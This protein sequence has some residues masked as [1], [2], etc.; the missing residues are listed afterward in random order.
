MTTTAEEA[1]GADQSGFLECVSV[2]GSGLC[3]S[4]CNHGPDIRLKQSKKLKEDCK[5]LRS[6]CRCLAAEHA[7]W[8]QPVPACPAGR[9]LRAPA[10]A[11]HAAP[12]GAPPPA[13][14]PEMRGQAPG[15]LTYQALHPT[16]ARC[17]FLPGLVG[18]AGTHSGVCCRCG[19]VVVGQRKLA[20]TLGP[21]KDGM[22]VTSCLPEAA[23]SC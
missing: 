8:V 11:P 1:P 12:P 10:A 5:Y 21:T 15:Q 9:G 18:C 17:R 2:P 3:S 4:T 22:L 6:G 20:W 14:H 7:D 13:V 23:G 19:I 16:S